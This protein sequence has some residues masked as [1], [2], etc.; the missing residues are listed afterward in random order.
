[1]R[2]HAIDHVQLAMPPGAEDR[3]R[4]F[5]AGVLGLSEQPKPAQLASR[6][7]LWFSGGEL[8]LH[9]GVEQEFRPARKAHSALLVQDLDA[10]ARRCVDAGHEPITD[11]PLPG[12]RRFYVADPF[13]NRIELLEPELG[14]GHGHG[15]GHAAHPV[16]LAETLAYVL[17]HLQGP[18][19]RLLEVGCGGGAL[20]AS[21]QAGGVAVRG[22]DLSPEAVQ[23]AR[24]RG[25]DVVQADFV[26]YRDMQTYDA[27]LFSRSLH[28]IHD[29][30]AALQNARS[31]LRPGG[32]LL[33]EDFG[34][35]LADAFTAAWLY[36]AE[37]LLV[38]AGVLQPHDGAA[39]PAA[40]PLQRWHAHH[41]PHHIAGSARL[42]EALQQTFP[43]C[44]EESAPYLYR[45][46]AERLNSDARGQAAASAL[47]DGERRA[48]ERRQIRA[49]GL[50]WTGRTE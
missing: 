22:V 49:I 23:E 30:G 39:D 37:A 8:R 47:L 20:A 41:D 27:V 12:Y 1:M 48:I 16:S 13:G 36:D 34:V 35:D 24:A 45:Y 9:L 38:A 50:R 46:L 42:R 26:E 7:G 14:A 10:L 21:L 11:Q 15:H 19:A 31:L 17:R 2:V 25:I 28:H 18:G 40:D 3:A 6:G 44:A 4:A 43:S 32:V 5:Y 29:L 33:V